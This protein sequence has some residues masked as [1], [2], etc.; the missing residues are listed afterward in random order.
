MAKQ[1]RI[2]T[3]RVAAVTGGARGIGRATAQALVGQGMKVG[4][5]DLDPDAANATAEAL[6]PAV[7][8]GP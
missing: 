2:L 5:G 8:R 3:G 7:D 1:A 6:G 4:I